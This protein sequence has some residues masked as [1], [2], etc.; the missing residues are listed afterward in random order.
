MG[1]N[2]SEEKRN[3]AMNFPKLSPGYISKNIAEEKCRE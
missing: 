3:I 1:I 2:L